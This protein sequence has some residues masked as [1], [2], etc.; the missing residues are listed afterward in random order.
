MKTNLT[1]LTVISLTILIAFFGCKKKGVEQEQ[2]SISIQGSTTVLPIMQ[3]IAEV[4]M[5][6]H[7][8]IKIDVSGG[9]SGVG[10]TAFIDGTIDIAMSSRKMKPE[11]VQNAKKKNINVK[12]VEIARDG[13]AVIVH[14]SNTI[15]NITLAQLHDI[16]IGKTTNWKALGGNDKPIVV[17]SRDTASG[18][19]EIFNERVLMKDKVRSDSLMQASNSAVKGAVSGSEDAIGYI[20]FGYISDDVKAI[21]VENIEI[22][23]ETVLSGTYPISRQLYIYLRDNSPKPIIDLVDFII[24]P[25]GQKIVEEVG[26]IPIK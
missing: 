17:I 9:G 4:Y 12:E 14:P 16:Y 13:I 15:T 18:T 22:S 21:K 24:G 25:E 10:I 23:K 8:D 26:F 3:R 19:Y 5:Q 1:L 11:E 6:K 20:G 7:P 2:V